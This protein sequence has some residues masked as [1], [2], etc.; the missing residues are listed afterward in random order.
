MPAILCLILFCFQ[1]SQIH[2]KFFCKL[3]IDK[4]I[5]RFWDEKKIVDVIR[6]LFCFYIRCISANQ[7]IRYRFETRFYFSSSFSVSSSCFLVFLYCLRT[8]LI[9]ITFS[10][11]HLLLI[12]VISVRHCSYCW[13]PALS[14]SLVLFSTIPL[15]HSFLYI[16]TCLN[17]YFLYYNISK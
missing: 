17:I 16:C 4:I 15:L 7:P 3:R 11:S 12:I 9:S 5:I 13:S 6:V 2:Y 10:F 8:P 14:L 1:V